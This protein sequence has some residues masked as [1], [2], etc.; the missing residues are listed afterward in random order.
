MRNRFAT[1][2]HRVDGDGAKQ[3][4]RSNDAYRWRFNEKIT[5]DAATV[6]DLRY[7]A[8]SESAKLVSLGESDD[9]TMILPET[10]ASDAAPL[11]TVEPA[12]GNGRIDLSTPR[13]PN[14]PTDASAFNRAKG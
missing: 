8:L 7:A 14:Q 6:R 1:E 5:V 10:E 3:A 12:A 9:E 13:S 11:D 2:T 4:T